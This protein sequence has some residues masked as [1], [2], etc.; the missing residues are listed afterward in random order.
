MYIYKL[1][2]SDGII[3]PAIYKK[4]T[5]SSK[6]TTTDG[7]KRF[8]NKLRG[9]VQSDASFFV[10]VGQD[11]KVSSIFILTFGFANNAVYSKELLVAGILCQSKNSF[12]FSFFINKNEYCEEQVLQDFSKVKQTFSLLTLSLKGYYVIIED[13]LICISRLQREIEKGND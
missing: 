8:I 9:S 11:G 2:V 3:H 5:F 6:I 4:F 7:L 12:I 10:S 1:V 13:K